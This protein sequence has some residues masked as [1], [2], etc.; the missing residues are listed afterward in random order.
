MYLFSSCVV[1]SAR[2]KDNFSIGLGKEGESNFGVNDGQLLPWR[3][4][5]S[6]SA[7]HSRLITDQKRRT[8]ICKLMMSLSPK[9]HN[10][11]FV[12]KQMDGS[13][14]WTNLKKT[15]QVSTSRAV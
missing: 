11:S 14:V 15:T 8:E 4:K 7:H 12:T 9:L 2:L 6:L 5:F 13:Q 3:P 10:R 1:V